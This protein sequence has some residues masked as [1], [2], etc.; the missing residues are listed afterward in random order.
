MITMIQM[1]AKNLKANSDLERLFFHVWTHL[2]P[3][4]NMNNGMFVMF[5]ATHLPHD[6]IKVL[7]HITVHN[8]MICALKGSDFNVLFLSGPK[9]GRVLCTQIISP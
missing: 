6:L 1:K 5:E 9:V 2:Q 7:A 8:D 3:E 4:L